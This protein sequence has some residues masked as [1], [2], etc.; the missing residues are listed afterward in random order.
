MKKKV[1]ILIDSASD[2]NQ[3]EAKEL[4]IAMIPMPVEIEGEEYLDGVTLTPT[5]FYEKLTTATTL[6]K[7][8]LINQYRWEEAIKDNLQEAETLVIITMSSKLS[9]TYNAAKQAAESFENQVFVVDSYTV[10]TAERMLCEYALT[11]IEKGKTAQEIAE[12][13]DKKKKH[14]YIFAVLTSLEQL[15]KGGRISPTVAFVGTALS[16]KPLVSTVDGE[17]KVVG[18]ALG[19]KKGKLSL[20]KLVLEK[21]GIDFSMPFAGLWSGL[22]RTNLDEYLADS[23]AILKETSNPIPC[24][25]VGGTIGTHVGAG[26]I[27]ITFFANEQN[28]G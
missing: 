20:N 12:A 3:A 7:T 15:K 10:A 27:G 28:E 5:A 2:I 26:A 23:R 4:G 14:L 11:L 18:K 9:G 16:L 22:D 6:P 21:G 1:K 24:F 25:I 17:V 8:S 19:A 13:L